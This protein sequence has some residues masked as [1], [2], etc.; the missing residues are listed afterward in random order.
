[1]RVAFGIKLLHLILKFMHLASFFAL[2][3]M[4][5]TVVAN[6]IGRIFFKAPVIGTLEVAGFCGV[7]F[8]SAAMGLAQRER[9]NIYV[10]IVVQRFS[11]RFRQISDSFTYFLSLIAVGIL[12]WAVTESAIEAFIDNDVTI[13][14]SVKT[15]PFRSI[16]AAGLFILGIFLVKHITE[17]L[18]GEA[19]K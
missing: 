12:C 6:I 9:R 7:I 16:W 1:M 13:T 18:R 5:L 14:L 15:F 19:K 10:D 3:V 17:F 11:I 2:M 8:V 4:M